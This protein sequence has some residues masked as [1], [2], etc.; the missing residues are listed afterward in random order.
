MTPAGGPLAWF[1]EM[2]PHCLAYARA[3]KDSGR[4]VMVYYAQNDPGAIRG[5]SED[6]VA[7]LRGAGFKVETGIVPGSGH[8]RHPQVAMRFRLR[9]WNGTPPRLPLMSPMRK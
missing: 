4:P 8:E 2:I 3:A 6:G 7:Y 9:H 1:S 5:Q